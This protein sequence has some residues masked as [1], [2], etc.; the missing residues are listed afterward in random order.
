MG[1]MTSCTCARI[2]GEESIDE[3]TYMFRLNA[4]TR[5][6]EQEYTYSP[7]SLGNTHS[8]VNFVVVGLRHERFNVDVIRDQF[9]LLRQALSGEAH[10]RFTLY[11]CYQ[12][13]MAWQKKGEGAH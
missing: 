8:T 2:S 12:P 1:I 10:I 11:T 3:T 9:V 7:N 6:C 13:T 5:T 4:L